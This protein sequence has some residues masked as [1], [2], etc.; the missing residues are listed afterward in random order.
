[1]FAKLK[2]G[3]AGPLSSAV[4][5]ISQAL[6]WAGVMIA[7]AWEVRGTPAADSVT[8]WLS[9]GAVTSLLLASD[10]NRRRRRDGNCGD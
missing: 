8:L 5:M 10:L 1:M 6:V 2:S 4:L 9:T 7:V 3:C